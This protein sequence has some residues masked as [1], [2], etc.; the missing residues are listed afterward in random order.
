MTGAASAAA[1]AAANAL[2]R[3][4]RD[5][6][7]PI[8][9]SPAGKLRGMMDVPPLLHRLGD[10]HWRPELISGAA[11]TLKGRQYS[12]TGAAYSTSDLPG[13]L[14]GYDASMGRPPL[15]LKSTNLLLPEG[16]GNGRAT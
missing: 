12:I 10:V 14:L 7:E 1:G 6:G 16:P 5:V 9:E 8:D 11:Y 4:R 3:A 13:D 2:K 15:H